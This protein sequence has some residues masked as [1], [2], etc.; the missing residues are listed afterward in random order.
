MITIKQHRF[1]KLKVDPD[2]FVY[3]EGR[4][5]RFLSF[6]KG[7]RHVE[8]PLNIICDYKI[9]RTVLGQKILTLY[10]KEYNFSSKRVVRLKP[11]H[12]T[13]LKPSVVTRLTELLECQVSWF[14]EME[15]MNE[16]QIW[17]RPNQKLLSS[18]TL[19]ST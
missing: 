6:G 9:S 11:I 17:T 13:F 8:L 5:S 14:Q 10:L 18:K 7:N 4:L 15:G 16:E 3:S 1:C 19:L 2:F 12:I